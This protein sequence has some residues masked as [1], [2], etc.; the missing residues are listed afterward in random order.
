MTEGLARRTTVKNVDLAK[1]LFPPY[2]ADIPCITTV[3]DPLRM[4]GTQH[5][6]RVLPQLI[7]GDMRVSRPV[8][9]NV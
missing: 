9:S 4:S 7:T 1:V 8:E 5:T 6:R 3:Y 2:T